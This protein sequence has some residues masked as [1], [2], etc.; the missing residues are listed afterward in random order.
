[1]KT[2]ITHALVRPPPPSFAEGL[3]TVALGKP[4][5]VAALAQHASYVAAIRKT[6]IEVIELPAL[7]DFPDSCFVE[8]AAVIVGDAV[9]ATQPG[10]QERRGEVPQL[11]SVLENY[12]TPIGRIS[13]DAT[14]DGG[15]VLEMG[16]QLFV[17]LTKRTNILGVEQ[18]RDIVA[19]L[20]WNVTPI[21]VPDI[22]HLKTGS[23]RLG[24]KTVSA[25]RCL[26]TPL[27]QEGLKVVEI[28]DHEGYA[29]NCLRIN[30]Y[31]LVPAD[32]PEARRLLEEAKIVPG[33]NI[34]DVE[35]NEFAK[36]D[37]GLTCL[38]RL[39]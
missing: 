36:Q 28:P 4:D 32:F 38:S 34:I 7:T 11:M 8:D 23:T 2:L 9:V 6:G 33:G 31:L 24:P 25:R 10:A 18:L 21:K 30:E 29:A 5:Y 20:G 39:W 14:L 12:L 37:G 16:R 26:A 27:G 15:D 3:T 17:G 22:L 35:M 19:P 13:G 1:M